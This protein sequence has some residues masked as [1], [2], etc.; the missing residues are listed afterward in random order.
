MQFVIKRSKFDNIVFIDTQLF[1]N[2]IRPK[3]IFK[4]TF[5]KTFFCIFYMSLQGSR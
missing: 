1:F 4:I 3:F 2:K 5:M